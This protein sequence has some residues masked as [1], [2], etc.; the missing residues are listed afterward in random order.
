MLKQINVLSEEL[1]DKENSPEKISSL[2]QSI[3]QKKGFLE[4]LNKKERELEKIF[5]LNKS[6]I[7]LNQKLMDDIS[8]I[9]ICPICKSKITKEH[10]HSISSEVQPKVIS[11]K[12]QITE[13]DKELKEIYLEMD[14]TKEEIKTLEAEFTKRDF[15]L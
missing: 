13:S 1:Y 9:D 5:F 7:N 2:K 3:I 11:L 4:E 8:K 14:S 15:D 6:E 12:K 10:I